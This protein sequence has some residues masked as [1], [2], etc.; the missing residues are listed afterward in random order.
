MLKNIYLNFSKQAFLKK[1]R[2][3]TRFWIVVARVSARSSSSDQWAS[4]VWACQWVL[5]SV[6]SSSSIRARSPC[7]RKP[8]SSERRALQR[9]ATWYF[10]ERQATAS[11]STSRDPKCGT[12]AVARRTI[13]LECFQWAARA[14]AAAATRQASMASGAVAAAGPRAVPAAS[15]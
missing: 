15:S 4:S 13:A 7:C 12:L 14:A 3:L 9:S 11:P 2:W 10:K 1:G 5:T 8:S 6:S